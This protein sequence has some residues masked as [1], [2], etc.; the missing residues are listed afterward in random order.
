MGVWN[1]DKRSGKLFKCCIFLFLLE[2][3][4]SNGLE[5]AYF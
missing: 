4:V 1:A 2:G 5:K 3:W